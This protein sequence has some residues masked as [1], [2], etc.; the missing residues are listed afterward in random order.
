MIY[1]RLIRWPNVLLTIITQVVIVYWYFPSTA[2]VKGLET[3]QEI[4]LIL[5]TA[6]LTA[7]GNVINDIYDVATDVINKPDQ[8]IVGKSITEKRA[9]TIYI[10]LTSTAIACGFILANSIQKPSLAGLFIGVAFLL[11]TYATTLKSILI[12]GNIVI[13]FLVGSVVLI[14]ALFELFPAVTALNRATQLSALQ[15]LAVFALFAFLVNL[16]REW[17]KDCQ[18]VK[19]DHASGR[20]S[21]PIVLGNK[22]AVQ[23]MAIYTLVCVVILGYLATFELYKDQRSL[24]YILF[25]IVAPL[26]FVGL[27]LFTASTLKEFKVLSLVCKLVLL[28]GVL[29]MG[30]IKFEV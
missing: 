16:L 5:A 6:L 27:R 10:F 4:L 23:F 19:G 12:V 30:I 8:V 14:T 9:F 13:S 2:A 29:G 3:W 15:H 1:L 11:Y 18:D 22:R 28:F 21:L 20:S 7:S 26:L 17:I 24:Y 25:L